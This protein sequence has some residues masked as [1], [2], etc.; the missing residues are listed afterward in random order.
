MKSRIENISKFKLN[1]IIKGSSS[2][3]EILIKIDVIVN[4]N[5][6]SYL[7]EKIK[8]EN[9]TF[10][11]KKVNPNLKHNIFNKINTK[12]KAYWLGFLAADGYITQKGYRISLDLSRKDEIQIDRFINFIGA[13][14]TSKKYKTEHRKNKGYRYENSYEK[15]YITIYSKQ[16]FLDLKKLNLD[17]PKTLKNVFIN[18]NNQELD[19]SFLLGFFDGDGCASTSPS[20]YSGIKSTLFSIKQKYNLKNK[21]SKNKNTYSMT[22]GTELYQKMLINYRKSL[23]RKRKL[24]IYKK[25]CDCGNLMSFKAKK[26]IKCFKMNCPEQSIDVKLAISLVKNQTP[27]SH[28]AKLFNI[29]DVGMVKILKRN[30]KDFESHSLAG[31]QK[32]EKD[33]IISLYKKGYLPKEILKKI[34]FKKI[35]RIYQ[36]ITEYRKG[37]KKLSSDKGSPFL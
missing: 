3:R 24:K 19:L 8:K 16:I 29:S 1:K 31:K 13:C 25:N 11:R 15:V 22:I 7:K 12:E 30:M 33:L 4:G 28:I 18:F 9:I 10:K 32:A 34:R 6:L 14:N 2:Y 23:P 5:N 21:I 20:L 26:C 35:D 17:S 27:I 37:S 36:I